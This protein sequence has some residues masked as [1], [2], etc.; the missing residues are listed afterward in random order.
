MDLIQN[1]LTK[2]NEPYEYEIMYNDVLNSFY[3]NDLT[4]L[5]II[6]FIFYDMFKINVFTFRNL[7]VI[8]NK[9]LGQC[10]FRKK[11]IEFYKNCII[12]GDD[13]E[14]CHACH[15]IEYSKTKNNSLENGLLL[16]LNN[17]NLFDKFYL[18]F[19]FKNNF[20]ALYDEYE[21]VL[22]EKIKNNKN[23][24]NY[25]GLDKNIVKINKNS[26]PYLDEKYDEFLT[27]NI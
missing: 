8:S 25:H 9:R 6:N 14:Q 7:S 22:N 3:D 17:H 16:N 2:Y 27:K 19:K 23:Y 15:I 5:H 13:F 26:K 11:L 21:I 1:F 20:N 18:G 24:K 12:S 4:N 10:I